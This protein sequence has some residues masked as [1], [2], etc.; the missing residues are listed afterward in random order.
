MSF[1]A[2]FSTSY[3]EK[4]HLWISLS[5]ATVFFVTFLSTFLANKLVR[6]EPLSSID[7]IA[8]LL[9]SFIFFSFGYASIDHVDGG[10]QFLGLFT[11]FTALLHFVAFVFLYK[12]QQQ[13]RDTFY[14][15]AGLVLTFLTLAVPVQLEGNWVTLVWAVEAC[16][17]FWIG[18]A[19]K[20]A[21]YENLSYPLILLSAV[22]LVHDWTETYPNDYFYFT[23]DIENT[24][25]LFL[26]IQFAT[27]LIVCGALGFVLRLNARVPR[28]GTNYMETGAL[29][30][31]LPSLLLFLLY[32]SFYKEVEA[33]WLHK[34]VASVV[35]VRS[36]FSDYPVYDYN[37]LSFKNIW[38][39]IY[40]ALFG[41]ALSFAQWRYIRNETLLKVCVVFN[42]IVGAA[43]VTLGL[44]EAGV[45]RNSYLNDTAD[46]QYYIR[47][48]GYILIRYAGIA[49]TIA[50][51]IVNYL[52][53]QDKV[54]NATLKQTERLLFHVAVL[55]I[56]SSELVHWLEMAH[57]QDSF[58]LAL[59]ILWGA[60]AL[61]LIVLGLR[62]NYKYIR[63]A[64]IVLFGVTLIKLFAY[65]MADMSTIAKTIVMIILGALLLIA[66]FLYNKFKKSNETA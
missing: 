43:F 58:K 23:S 59:S 32:F 55:I 25:R 31:V 21:A 65:D 12:R 36:E 5:F 47:N 9:N 22:S 16:L 2:W 35:T 51:M 41:L 56:L 24:F 7:I 39:I 33:Y 10:D 20:F 15:V 13:L 3:D 57:I 48:V 53:V 46:N 8:T 6:K 49:A 38:L 66:S 54:F 28:S 30:Y 40:S 37:L 14:F 60:Y 50:L 44:Y 26:N 34:Y 62:K 1:A 29:K 64:A 61:F 52:F 4:I 17:L 19:K 63:V 45:L 42:T 27:S 18:R 11:V